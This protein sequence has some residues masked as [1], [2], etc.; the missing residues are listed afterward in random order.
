[1][2]DEK[3]A[4]RAELAAIEQKLAVKRDR[5]VDCYRSLENSRHGVYV[6]HKERYITRKL[7]MCE[8]HAEVKELEF[9]RHIAECHYSNLLFYDWHCDE[10]GT[11]DEID[12][13]KPAK[14]TV[15]KLWQLWRYV[16]A[17]RK[18]VRALGPRVPECCPNI[19]ANNRDNAAHAAA[20]LAE[21]KK[22]PSRVWAE[23]FNAVDRAHSLYHRAVRKFEGRAKW[24]YAEHSHYAWRLTGPQ[25]PEPNPMQRIERRIARKLKRRVKQSAFNEPY[26]STGPKG[27]VRRA[28]R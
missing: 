25:F 3:I 28:T 13:I 1:M 16:L 14:V 11:L 4:A 5:Y 7:E 17:A 12:K 21:L 22:I 6:L 26:R 2:A 8:V 24:D 9:E 10:I 20:A 23:K 27:P 19:F 15:N 18:H